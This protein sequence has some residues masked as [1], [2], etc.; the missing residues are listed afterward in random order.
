MPRITS[1]GE[2]LVASGLSVRPGPPQP[3]NTTGVT[4]NYN[5]TNN[6][7]AQVAINSNDFTQTLTVEAKADRVNA[8]ADALDQYIAGEPPNAD[9]VRELATEI[10]SAAGAPEENKTKLQ[11]LL[12][13]AIGA[14]TAAAGTEIGQLVT[15]LALGAI[16]SLG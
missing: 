8:V 14:V 1:A 15:Q 5:I 9:E 6:A 4:N 10:R 3:A 2:K 13:A 16:Q 12:A 11:A 7:P